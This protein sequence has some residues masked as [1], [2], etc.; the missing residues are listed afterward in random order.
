MLCL[1]SEQVEQLNSRYHHREKQLDTLLSKLTLKT[2]GGG[3]TTGVV[4]TSSSN[5]SSGSSNGCVGGPPVTT[6]LSPRRLPLNQFTNNNDSLGG[7]HLTMGKDRANN[8][9][10]RISAHDILHMADFSPSSS[11]QLYNDLPEM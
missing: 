10:T 4:I 11:F 8:N 2:T 6:N 7:L 5:S 3:C 9:S 1:L